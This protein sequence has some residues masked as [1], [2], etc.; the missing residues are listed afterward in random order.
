MARFPSS[1]DLIR[2]HYSREGV[3]ISWL[4]WTSG[5]HGGR[6]DLR[7]GG[8]PLDRALDPLAEIDP[9]LPPGQLADLARI[10]VLAVDLAAG[11]P[12]PAVLGLDVG[13]AELADQ[14]DDLAHGM[15]PTPTGVERLAARC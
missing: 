15:R 8:V 13:R 7:V 11:V 2:R 4:F 3:R 1:P 10:E 6:P 14:L 9:R 5:F 12:R